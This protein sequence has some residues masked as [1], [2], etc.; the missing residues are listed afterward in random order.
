MSG[1]V[2]NADF[3]ANWIDMK[4]KGIRRTAALPPTSTSS[5]CTTMSNSSRAPPL[6]VTFVFGLFVWLAVVSTPVSVPAANAQQSQPGPTRQES[7]AVD[8]KGVR[9]RM[10]DYA[11]ERAP[12]LSDM[13]K[14]VQPEYPREYRARRIEGTAIFR[15]IVDASSGSVTSVKLIK[16]SGH[17]GLDDSASRAIQQW[18]WRP[19]TWTE[20]DMP[21]AFR[22]RSAHGAD[23]SARDLAA[24]GL[25]SY[26]KGDNDGAIRLSSQALQRDP[27]LVPAYINRGAAY[28]AKRQSDQALV[29]FSEVI[30]LDP[31][32]AKA[33]C[34][35]G[36]LEDTELHQPEKALADYNE[37]IRL[38]PEF[39]R[40]YVNRA[41]HFMAQHDYARAVA[42][43]TRAIEL[44]PNDLTAHAG[45]AWA[46]AK[47]NDRTH[48]R[49]DAEAA[50]RI[51][52]ST[53][54]YLWRAMDL[55]QRAKAHR[56]L[57]QEEAALR[58]LRAA[59]D[60]APKDPAYQNSVAWL[61]ATCP[62]ERVRDGRQAL[63]VAK[64]ACKLSHWQRAAYIDTMAA[65]YG[66]TGDFD[67]AI[68]FEKQSLNETS[69]TAENKREREKHLSLFQQHKPVREDVFDQN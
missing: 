45:R 10:S 57:G 30:R 63:A 22:T 3:I 46:Y 38:A 4:I 51:A 48:A 16:S 18:R 52:P 68:K 27:T 34:D 43:Y 7:S 36:N 15:I 5:P 8:A 59:A 2:C 12:W 58:D 32:N 61:L 11:E 69:L 40:A 26:R 21:V 23:G 25:A 37:A 60:A 35:R 53:E 13:V 50:L 41:S 1:D 33:Y 39:H 42:D 62:E 17:S 49:A 55:G 29:D 14:F 31:K 47:Q 54:F 66:E 9:H 64:K 24:R 20:I 56:M 28:Q 6:D 44:K 65:A 67:Q 19:H